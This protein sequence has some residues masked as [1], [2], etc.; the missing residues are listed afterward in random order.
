VNDCLYGIPVA[1]IAKRCGVH[2]RTAM[3]WKTGRTRMPRTAIMVMTEDLGTFDAAWQGW[4]LRDRKLISPE[5][6]EAGPG[7]VLS[8]PLRHAQVQAYQATERSA[9]AMEEQ[10]VP[11]AVPDF[12]LKSIG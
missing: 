12:M 10:P 11:G 4:K 6:W 9:K 7:D 1:E 3:R 8:I 2:I 5:G